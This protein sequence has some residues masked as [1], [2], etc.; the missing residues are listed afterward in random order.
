MIRYPGAD[1][2]TGEP[3]DAWG[4]REREDT[5][6]FEDLKFLMYLCVGTLAV[7]AFMSCK[8]FNW[9]QLQCFDITTLNFPRFGNLHK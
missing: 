7:L 5:G 8:C 3:G 4:Q 6:F 2:L 9:E 1:D